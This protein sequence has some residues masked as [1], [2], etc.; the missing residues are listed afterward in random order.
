MDKSE[1]RYTVSR[2]RSDDTLFG[3]IH[4]GCDVGG[5]PCYET[6][7]GQRID[8]HWWIIGDMDYGHGQ[9][10]CKKCLA[11]LRPNPVLL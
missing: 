4:G 1:A 11:E 5:S 7:C 10:T 2:C 3:P 6:L 9:I 8:D